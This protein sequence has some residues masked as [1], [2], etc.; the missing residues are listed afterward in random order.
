LNVCNTWDYNN[1][2]TQTVAGSITDTFTY[3]PSGQRLSLSNGSSTT[4]YASKF[5]N[6]D[7]TTAQKHIFANG[8]EVATVEG[9]GEKAAI[10]STAT[11]NLTGSNV[12]TDS[13]NNPEEVLDYFP[14]GSVRIDQK[15]GS[16]GDQRQYAG[17][18]FDSDTGLNYMQ[19]RYYDSGIGRFVSQDPAFLAVGDKKRLENVTGDKI[20]LYLF[21]PQGLNSYSYVMNNPL[22]RIDP[23]GQWIWDLV[24]GKQ[25]WNDFVVEVGDAANILY[26]NSKVW[27][28]ALDHPYIAGA[29][30]GVASGA[31]AVGASAVA[32]AV[33]TTYL[34]GVG[35]ACIA[36]CSTVTQK[37]NSFNAVAQQ[38]EWLEGVTNTRAQR[39][40][41]DVFRT[42]DK[43]PG[44]TIEA[45]RR[46]VSTGER[47]GNKGHIIKGWETVNRINNILNS[48]KL[49]PMEYNKLN[50]IRVQIEGALTQKWK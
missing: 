12:T 10:H 41:K 32:A 50:D 35:T 25:S 46:E 11:D 1:R 29:A 20:E 7:G 40:V 13:G 3:D 43:I 27:H 36:L 2:I 49:N 17:S 15:S 45:I 44:G 31:A 24:T 26:D 4:Y 8:V 33:S 18:E 28:T 21:N 22:T 5:Y 42:Q 23:D 48:E 34:G 37:A 14:F 19:A 16:Y 30:V 6:T 39:V 38:N 47:V 9:T